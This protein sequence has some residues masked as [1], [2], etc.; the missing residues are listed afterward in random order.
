MNIPLL[1]DHAGLYTDYYELAMSRAYY[2]QGK[3]DDEAVFDY[4]FRKNPF[5]GGYVL[6]SGINELLEILEDLHYSQKELDYLK[7]IG[8]DD[9]FLNYL[10]RFSFTATIKAP[11]EGEVVFPIEPVLTVK[12]KIIEIQIIETML[13]NLLNFSSLVATK[14]SRI[15]SAAGGRL[16]TDFGLRR[17]QGTGGI[18]ASRAAIVGGA[19]STSNVISGYLYGLPVSGTMAHSW[20][21][22]FDDELTAFRKFAEC[23]PDNTVLLLDTYNT[24]ISGIPNAIRVAKEMEERGERMKGIRLDSGDLAYLSKQARRMLD[25]AGLDYVKIIVSNQLDEAVIRSLNLQKAPIDGFGIGTKLITGMESAAIDGVYKLSEFNGQPRMKISDNIEKTTL[26]GDKRTVRYLNSDG[27][28]HGDGIL[29]ESEAQTKEIIHPYFNYK[30]TNVEDLKQENIT[31]KVMVNGKRL[32][33]GK[34]AKESAEYARER[35]SKLPEE[36]HRLEYP[37]HFKVG[38]SR[39]LAK[40]RDSMFENI[41]KKEEL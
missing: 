8:F 14:A 15:R 4:F 11:R 27:T 7:K 17:A 36:H 37:H 13:L 19:D 41:N 31:R 5:N 39:K 9:D 34:T 33:N 22:T 35:L 32:S 29:L 10:A 38:I 40:M 25:N 6:F 30:R 1:K 2:L 12:G 18:T 24:I 23:Y 28:F 3:A 20:I 16:F 21:Q 26:P